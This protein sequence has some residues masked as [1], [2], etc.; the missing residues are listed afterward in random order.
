MK[1]KAHTKIVGCCCECGGPVAL[2]HDKIEKEL[3]VCTEC[4]REVEHDINE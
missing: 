1:T 4:G 2:V 3:F